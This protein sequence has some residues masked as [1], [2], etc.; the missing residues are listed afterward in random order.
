MN[1]RSRRRLVTSCVMSEWRELRTSAGGGASVRSAEDD[2]RAATGDGASA[3]S[4]D[5]VSV[6]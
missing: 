1:E 2:R 5:G 6:Q 4:E 3:A